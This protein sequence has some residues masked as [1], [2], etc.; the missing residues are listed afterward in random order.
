MILY[1][2]FLIARITRVRNSLRAQQRSSRMY[3]RSSFCH[4]PG[5][6]EGRPRKRNICV[7]PLVS[8]VTPP[9][10]AKCWNWTDPGASLSDELFVTEFRNDAFEKEILEHWSY[11]WQTWKICPWIAEEQQSWSGR[12]NPSFYWA[13][14]MVTWRSSV[15]NQ[16]EER[17]FY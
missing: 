7:D 16:L 10:C 1:H 9:P 8:T 3:G 14:S 13:Y 12:L 15:L 5:M 17:R 2:H 4:D 11:S 6:Q